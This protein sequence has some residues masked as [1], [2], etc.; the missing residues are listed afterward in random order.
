MVLWKNKIGR[1]DKPIVNPTLN[2]VTIMENMD[3]KNSLNNKPVM[4]HMNKHKTK[5]RRDPNI[6]QTDK[7]MYSL[8]PIDQIM[9]LIWMISVLMVKNL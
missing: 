4:D 1:K 7:P 2:I 3:S 9:N 5:D 6:N 8:D